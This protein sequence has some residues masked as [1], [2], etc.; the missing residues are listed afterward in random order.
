M[1]KPFTK[2]STTISPL[3]LALA[4]AFPLGASAAT[5]TTAK[6]SAA[7]LQSEIDEL[8]KQIA[9]LRKLVMEKAAAPVP[10][11]ASKPPAPA[12]APVATVDPAEFNRVRVKVEAMEDSQEA[13]GIKGLKISGM[14][15]PVYIYNDRASRGS[16]LFLNAQDGEVNDLSQDAFGYDNS[17]FGGVSIKFEKDLGGGMMAMVNLRPQKSATGSATIV[18]EALLTVPLGG[19]MAAVAGKAI[20]FNGYE[21]TDSFQNK[22]ITHNLLW[23]F[24]GP[25][26]VTGAGLN[27][28]IGSMAFKTIVG[29]L[30]TYRDLPGDDNF[31]AH[32]RGDITLGEFSGWGISG[33][34]GQIYDSSYNYLE[35]DYWYTRGDLTLNAQ[36][37]GS[38]MKNGAFNGG[39]ATTTGVSVLAAYK[40]TPEWEAR[41]RGDYLDN[42]KNGGGGPA[43]VFGGLCPDDGTGTATPAATCG[44]YRNGF[45]PGV[46]YNAAAGIWELGNINKGTERTALTLGLNYQYNDNGL[47][48]FEYR[49]DHSNLNSFVNDK[50]TNY[51]NSNSLIGVQT[52]VK[53]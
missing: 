6:P 22:S 30:N 11:M 23:D 39:N 2:L 5:Q 9:E 33:M 47:L 15:D 3:V 48:K 38:K 12:P 28:K 49:Y 17:N 42:G 27:F 51:K 52:V 16:F 24:G 13:N 31:G 37:E 36:I 29:N 1:T 46:N 44:D 14:I 32:W 50:G 35:A 41:I 8:K 19:G 21:Y 18:E 10:V 20:S 25:S 4:L 40:L 53:F 26:F 43:V 34:H 7:Q 45:G